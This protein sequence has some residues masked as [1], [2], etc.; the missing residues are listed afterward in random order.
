[1]RSCTLRV[2]VC[3]KAPPQQPDQE[4]VPVLPIRKL[5]AGSPLPVEVSECGPPSPR[6]PGPHAGGQAHLGQ[7]AEPTAL[8][9]GAVP[10]DVLKLIFTKTLHQRTR[11][12]V[13]R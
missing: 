5:R 10:G 9:E 1:M 3:R 8:R 12:L 2:R 11:I 13:A 6:Q 4:C 7:R